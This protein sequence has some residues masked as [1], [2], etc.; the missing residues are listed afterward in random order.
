MTYLF[1]YRNNASNKAN[2]FLAS[3]TQYQELYI[4]LE[5]GDNLKDEPEGEY[6]YALLPFCGNEEYYNAMTFEYAGNFL[7]TMVHCPDA[8]IMLRYLNPAIGTLRIGKIGETNVYDGG[9]NKIY[10]YEG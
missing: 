1:V 4:T 6:T 5:V 8:S 2:Y 10:F 3:G 9:N 7:D